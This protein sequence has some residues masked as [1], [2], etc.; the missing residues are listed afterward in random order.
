MARGFNPT[1]RR[2]GWVLVD[3]TLHT[4][5]DQEKKFQKKFQKKNFS[6]KSILN[7]LTILLISFLLILLHN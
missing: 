6:K 5:I 7:I 1:R 4:P 2:R 3:Y